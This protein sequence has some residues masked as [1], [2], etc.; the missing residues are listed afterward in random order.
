MPG[1]ILPQTI[2]YTRSDSTSP[3]YPAADVGSRRVAF[4]YDDR[5]VEDSYRGYRPMAGGAVSVTKR[6]SNI[7]TF[8]GAELISEY[9]FH[10][11]NWTTSKRTILHAMEKCDADEVCL[12]YTLFDWET[13]AE[14]TRARFCQTTPSR[15]RQASKTSPRRS[16]WTSTT[17]ARWKCS[18]PPSRGPATN[19]RSG[20]CG[21]P[22]PALIP[23]PIA[24]YF[25]EG[26][27]CAGTVCD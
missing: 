5:A 6:L 8:V 18:T 27:A 24:A 2:R 20:S 26:S 23:S 9:R 12:P 11:K 4:V 21:I 14:A 13:G 22:R 19:R 7:E 25:V 1:E 16:R 17:T 3:L 10:Y 15:R